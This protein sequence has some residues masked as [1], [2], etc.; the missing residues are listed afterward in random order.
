MGLSR[1][2]GAPAA[3]LALSGRAHRYGFPLH[4]TFRVWDIF[5][6]KGFSFALQAPPNTPR[7]WGGR[8][9]SD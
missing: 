2:G 5:F 9:V 3:A 8:G 4:F 1:N 7:S 6:V